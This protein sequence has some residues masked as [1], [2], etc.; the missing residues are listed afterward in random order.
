VH[1]GCV[2]EFWKKVVKAVDKILVKYVGKV[3]AQELKLCTF[4]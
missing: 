3:D 1:S 2:S 4:P